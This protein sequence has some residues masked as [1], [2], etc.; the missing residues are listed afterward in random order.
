MIKAVIF[1]LDNTLVDFMAMKR[2]AVDAAI[3]A[4]RDAGLRLP[5][6]EIRRRIDAIYEQRGIE[7]QNVFDQLLFDEFSKIDYKILSSGIIAYRRAREAALVPYPHVYMTLVELA[8]MHLKLAVVSDAPAREA[9]LRL[10]YLNFHHIFDVVVTF[11]DTGER[12]PNPGPFRKALERLGVKP[13]EALMVGDWAERDVVGAKQVGMK[14]V[15]AR[16]GDTFG[17]VVS[18]ADYDIDDIAQVID[19]VR[20]E[21]G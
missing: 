19:I 21:N 8:K 16:Y 7:F 1:D 17:T 15:F 20:K 5:V 9:W 12:K 14:T 3:H 4:M 13:E 6:E 18:N 2:Q 11:D 10:C